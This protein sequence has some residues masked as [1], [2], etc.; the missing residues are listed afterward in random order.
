[1]ANHWLDNHP[2][3]W[4]QL[5]LDRESINAGKLDEALAS[6]QWGIV[7]VAWEQDSDSYYPGWRILLNRIKPKV[8]N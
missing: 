8:K 2:H 6:K 5:S 7:S 1:M 3:D 4:A